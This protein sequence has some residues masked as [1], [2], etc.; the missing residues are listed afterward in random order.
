MKKDFTWFY[1]RARKILKLRSGIW[2][3]HFEMSVKVHSLIQALALGRKNLL[4]SIKEQETCWSRDPK[5]G[6]R[7][8]EQAFWNKHESAFFDTISRLLKKDFCLILSEVS[9]KHTEAEIWNLVREI[10]NK[11]SQQAWKCILW[12]NL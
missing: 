4:D 5:S 6:K 3:K 11:H 12:Y 2:N 1:Q 10:C 9:K 8:V 7:N